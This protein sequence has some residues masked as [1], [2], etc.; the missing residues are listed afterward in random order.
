MV[1]ADSIGAATGEPVVAPARPSFS[2]RRVVGGLAVIAAAGGSFGVTNAALAASSRS[3]AS[4]GADR[5]V[6]ALDD[7]ER[8]LVSIIATSSTVQVRSDSCAGSIAG[9]GVVVDGRVLTAAHLVADTDRAVVGSLG[10]TVVD[11]RP[12]L[13]LAVVVPEGRLVGSVTEVRSSPVV[14]GEPVVVAGHPGGGPLDVVEAW[15]HHVDLGAVWGLDTGVVVLDRALPA[16]FSGGPVL[17]RLGRLVGVVH[18]YDA[19]SDLSIVVPA[20]AADVPTG[21]ATG[22]GTGTATGTDSQPPGTR[23]GEGR[24]CE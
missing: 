9:A 6:V 4:S 24:A 13:D 15:V 16:G 23:A 22:A 21:T 5:L 19:V 20:T 11:R 18:G 1:D 2:R 10:G 7:D 14:A 8:R 12:A 17:D 3:R